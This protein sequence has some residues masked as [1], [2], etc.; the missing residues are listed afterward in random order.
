M[1]KYIMLIDIDGTICD[2]IPNEMSHTFPDAEPLPGAIEKINNWREEGAEI[3]FF[4]ARTEEHRKVTEEWL[5]KWGFNYNSLV[6]N[7]PRI[8]EGQEYVWIDNRYV[9]AITFKGIWSNLVEHT[10]KILSFIE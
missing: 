9:R 2:D 6:M 4:T 8:S 10:K 3:H 7:K 5:D 1:E